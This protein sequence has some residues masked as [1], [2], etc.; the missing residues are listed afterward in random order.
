MIS[1]KALAFAKGISETLLCYADGLR[2]FV[3]D[4]ADGEIKNLV[5]SVYL[6]AKA[7]RLLLKDDKETIEMLERH[8][9]K[10]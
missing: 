10:I 8:G 6:G 5:L 7:I 9:W 2:D 1:E 4:N 3:D